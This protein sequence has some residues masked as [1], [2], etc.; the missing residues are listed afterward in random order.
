[1][2]RIFQYTAL[3]SAIILVVAIAGTA[4]YS[5]PNQTHQGYENAFGEEASQQN[6]NKQSRPAGILGYLFPDSLSISTFLLVI[7]TAAMAVVA[8]MQLNFLARAETISAN[9]SDAAQKTAEIA[10]RTLVASHRHGYGL[11]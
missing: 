7:A 11:M 2:L 9:A 8:A 1:M 3:I 4:Y 10:K 5:L 6:S